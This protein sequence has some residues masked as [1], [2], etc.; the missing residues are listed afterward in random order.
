MAAEVVFECDARDIDV[1]VTFGIGVLVI[2]SDQGRVV[3]S[4]SKETLERLGSRIRGELSSAERR[5]MNPP[6]N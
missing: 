3:V 1:R 6:S 5:S 4:T 2:K